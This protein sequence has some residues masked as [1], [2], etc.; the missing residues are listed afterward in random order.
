MF[1]LESKYYSN[2]IESKY[3]IIS[4]YNSC[5]NINLKYMK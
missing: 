5:L 3:N 2:N 1:L 4:K